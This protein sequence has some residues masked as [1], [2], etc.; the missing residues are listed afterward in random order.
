MDLTIRWVFQ[1]QS[2]GN[3]SC[4]CNRA[5]YVTVHEGI[6]YVGFKRQQV[7]RD[8]IASTRRRAM[9]AQRAFRCHDRCGVE[10][11]RIY[12]ILRHR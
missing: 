8:L 11:R 5:G 10:R 7:L 6:V 3:W 9:V 12:S 4:S 2:T 1:T